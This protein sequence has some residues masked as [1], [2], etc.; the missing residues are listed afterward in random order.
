MPG[1]ADC[2]VILDRLK[3]GRDSDS[4]GNWD[5]PQHAPNQD[6]F[7]RVRMEARHLGEHSSAVTTAL[8]SDWPSHGR[9]TAVYAA[10]DDGSYNPGHVQSRS[11]SRALPPSAG[12]A[13]RRHS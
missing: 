9:M 4:S 5:E 7:I 11:P 8:D 13:L 12:L 6:R 1:S 10:Q 2:G 3:P